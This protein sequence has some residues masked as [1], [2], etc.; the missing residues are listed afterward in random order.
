[1]KFD[2]GISATFMIGYSACGLFLPDKSIAI[3]L[4]VLIGL[5]GGSIVA[6]IFGGM[7]ID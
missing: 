7:A 3:S 4:I 6:G 2:K 5:V 1:M